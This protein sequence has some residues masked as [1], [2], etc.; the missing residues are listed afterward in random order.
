MLQTN[1]R[2]PAAGPGLPKTAEELDGHSLIVYVEDARPPNGPDLN[3][4]LK[5]GTK[6]DV[7]RTAVLSVNNVYAIMRAVQAGVGIAA[8]PEFMVHGSSDLVRVF[9]ELDGPRIDAYFVY[10]EELRNS[11]RIQVFRDFLLLQVAKS[12]F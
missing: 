6:A 7:Q 9:P 4:L 12:Q 1:R 5:L 3:W 8:L 2:P 10:P 11:K